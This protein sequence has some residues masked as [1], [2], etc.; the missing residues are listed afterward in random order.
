MAL[1]KQ[2]LRKIG[3]AILIA[4]FACTVLCAGLVIGSS[5]KMQ[6]KFVSAAEGVWTDYATAPNDTTAG[7]SRDNPIRIG[8]SSELAWLAQEVNAGNDFSG[9][10]IELNGTLDL[11][12]HNWVP[13]G[14]ADNPFRGNITLRGSNVPVIRNLTIDTNVLL[15]SIPNLNY[16]GLFGYVDKGSAQYG[17]GY[18]EL[19]ILENININIA[20]ALPNSNIYVGGLVGYFNGSPRI[21][22]GTTGNT[23]ADLQATS[24]TIYLDL[25]EYGTNSCFVGGLVGEL[26]SGGGLGWTANNSYVAVNFDTVNCVGKNLYVG[27]IVGQNN[28]TITGINSLSINNTEGNLSFNVNAGYFGGVVGN[29]T[30]TGVIRNIRTT[31]SIVSDTLENGVLAI[32]GIAGQNTNGNIINCTNV[33]QITA[34]S[35]SV[36]GIAG[37]NINASAVIENSTNSGQIVIYYGLGINAGGIAGQNDS[38]QVRSSSNTGDIEGIGV[39]S[40][41]LRMSRR[42]G[43]IVGINTSNAGTGIYDCYNTANIGASLTV[44]YVGGIAGW[45]QGRISNATSGGTTYGFNYNTGDICGAYYVGGIAGRNDSII[46][47]SYN[48][49]DVWGTDANLSRVGGIVGNSES[50]TESIEFCFNM[51]N[52][53]GN[54]TGYA[55]GITGQVVSFATLENVINYGNVSAVISAGGLIGGSPE[56]RSNITLQYVMSV[57]DVDDAGADTSI[58]SL[59][60]LIGNMHTNAIAGAE[61][62]TNAIY[63]KSVA[64]YDENLP[65]RDNGMGVTANNVGGWNSNIRRATSYNLTQPGA[66]STTNATITNFV[67]SGNWYFAPAIDNEHKHFYPILSCFQDG[68]VFATET[69]GSGQVAYPEVIIYAVNFINHRPV[70]WNEG[71]SQI[72]YTDE[73]INAFTNAAPEY[74]IDGTQYINAGQRLSEPAENTYT[75]AD[76]YTEVWR[77]GAES[78][79]N[80]FSFD[81]AIYQDT[82]VYLTWEGEQ[83]NVIFYLYNQETGS[84]DLVTDFVTYPEYWDGLTI[85]YTLDPTATMRIDGVSGTGTTFVGWWTDRETALNGI[86]TEDYS[87][88]TLDFS[89]NVQYTD[90]LVIYGSIQ[91]VTVTVTIDAGSIG[92]TPMTFADGSRTKQVQITYNSTYTIDVNFSSHDGWSFMGYFSTPNAGAIQYTDLS[93]NSLSPSGFAE[94]GIILYAQW[95]ATS[96]NV[97]FASKGLDGTVV[98]LVTITVDYNTAIP[99]DQIPDDT[100]INYAMIDST[101]DANGYRIQDFY[102]TL[103]CVTGTEFDFDTVIL[104]ETYI[105]VGWEVVSFEL[106]LNANGGLFSNGVGTYRF[107]VPYGQDIIQAIIGESSNFG[108][109]TYAGFSPLSENGVLLWSVTSYS[110][111]ANFDVRDIVSID[112]NN[113]LMPASSLQLYIVWETENF[114]IYLRSN[115]GAFADGS[116]LKAISLAF[117]QNV[118]SALNQYTDIIPTMAGFGFR[119]WS[120]DNDEGAMEI[121][122]NMTMPSEDLT[123]YAIWGEQVTITF[124]VLGISEEDNMLYTFPVFRGEIVQDVEGLT[125]IEDAVNRMVNGS[126]FLFD[127]WEQIINPDTSG[128]FDTTGVA[129]NF[130]TAIIN[131]DIMLMATLSLDPNFN[132]APADTTNYLIIAIVVILV[133]VVLMFLL[134]WTNMRKHTMTLEDSKIKNKDIKKQLDEI[135]ELER[136]RK[137]LDNPYE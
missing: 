17:S 10:Y 89:R 41:D 6:S 63:N 8:T 107:N 119:F 34:S 48:T 101:K 91:F 133:A 125:E 84:F 15:E 22:G 24:G 92:S 130:D 55:G 36:G 111:G 76:G 90:G 29:N 49:G 26:A 50:L 82:T 120:Q 54:N 44:G 7:D 83:Y 12:A 75:H 47:Y 94:D 117:G 78:T 9:R 37:I 127:H 27:G 79:A 121:D 66:E 39:I 23:G 96:Q 46:A 77:T 3:I 115:G 53:G 137:E 99:V 86:L 113:Y 100:E 98:T 72:D 88:A 60:G 25:A 20:G 18:L 59:G 58:A 123:L 73:S 104:G 2:N 126:G 33:G 122:E 102:T 38:G 69:T 95:I 42:V 112:N 11:S 110:A 28:G 68:V 57:G 131:E 116:S 70:Q 97:I 52:I 136:R 106:T 108:T 129:F 40:T 51:G 43:G 32:G 134:I 74:T 62:I 30:S 85:Q 5:N 67:N 128:N 87:Q 19:V 31:A 45:N 114:T 1:S 21:S 64:N 14:T 135:K 132:P 81:T 4:I 103:D 124:Y 56:A 93:G 13:I 71:N 118:L 16:I 105:Y 80:E 109:P 61:N 35:G 65:S